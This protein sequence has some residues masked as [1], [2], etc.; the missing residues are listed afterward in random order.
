[1]LCSCRVWVPLR[2]RTEGLFEEDSDVGAVHGGASRAILILSLEAPRSS[3]RG[4]DRIGLILWHYLDCM[5]TD[6]LSLDTIGWLAGLCVRALRGLLLG[7]PRA[8]DEHVAC[9]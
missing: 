7:S 9:G 6:L 2:G 4:F 8:S 1:M 3:R 5:V